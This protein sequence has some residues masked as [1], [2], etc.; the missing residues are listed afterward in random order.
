MVDLEKYCKLSL[1]D[2]IVHAH[3]ADDVYIDLAI[4]KAIVVERKKLAKN[5]PHAVIITG[6]PIT[7]S[8]EARKYALCEES[9]ELISYWAIVTEENLLKLTFYK[10]LFFTQCRK[11]NMKF[12]SDLNSAVNWIKSQAKS[13]INLQLEKAAV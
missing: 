6:G 10:L 5:L 8:A 1:V 3:Y 7:I 9:N 2:G 13:V 12:F 4:A 11:H